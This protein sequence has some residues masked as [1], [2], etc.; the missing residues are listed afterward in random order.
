MLVLFFFFI[1][2]FWTVGLTKQEIWI[3]DSGIWKVCKSFF[4]F[5]I[6]TL[7]RGNNEL[8]RFIQ[9]AK[10]LYVLFYV[11]Q[12]AKYTSLDTVFSTSL[13]LLWP[14]VFQSKAETPKL[15]A[16]ATYWTNIR[17]FWWIVLV[18]PTGARP[19]LQICQIFNLSVIICV[20]YNTQHF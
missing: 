9:S 11:V 20:C 7:K 4:F 17:R 12:T 6:L 13:D 5:H 2:G 8:C 1:F 16:P 10:Q 18:P 19:P 15:H 14:V 3:Y